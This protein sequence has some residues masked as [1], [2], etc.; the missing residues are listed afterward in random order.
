MTTATKNLI[1]VG[2]V[3]EVKQRGC[4]VVTGGGHTIAVFRRDDA[5]AAVDNRCPH[6]GFPLNRGTVEDGILTCHWHHA[7]FDLASGCT[8]NLFADDVDAYPV[9][10]K[11]GEVYL[12][13]VRPQRDPVTRWSRRLREGMEQNLSLI[14]GK[15]VIGLLHSGVT[16]DEI[17]KLGALYGV[18]HR[19]DWAS[20]LTIL[21]AMAN[22]CDHLEGDDRIAPLFHGLVHVA[23]DCAGMTPKFE[24]SP[25]DNEEIPHEHLKRWLRYFVEVRSTEGAERCLLTA[26]RKGTSGLSIAFSIIAVLIAS[27]IGAGFVMAPHPAYACSCVENPPPPEALDRSAVV[28]AGRVVSL[29][30]HERPGDVWSGADPGDGRVRGQ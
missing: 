4:M 6:M 13:T 24:I 20:G 5:F 12:S 17:A 16:P 27:L 14:I 11:E 2:S 3:E 30:L 21:S 9:E 19:R 26:V 22:L 23:R 1:K 25:L 15:S 8:F 28:F 7:R 18:R 29:K 10:V